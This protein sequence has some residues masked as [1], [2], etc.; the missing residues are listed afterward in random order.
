[1]KAVILAGA[2]APGIMKSGTRPKPMAKLGVKPPILLEYNEIFYS[3]HGINDLYLL[4][5]TKGT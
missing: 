2:L 5:V 3:T 4:A 1:V